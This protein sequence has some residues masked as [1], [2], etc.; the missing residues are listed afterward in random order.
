[1]PTC[2]TRY[3]A[4][5]QNGYTLLEVVVCLTLVALISGLVLRPGVQAQHNA[6]LNKA[7]SRLIAALEDQ[8]RSAISN[9]RI[10]TVNLSNG[11]LTTGAGNIYSAPETF[12]LAPKKAPK[13]EQLKPIEFYPDGSVNA[14]TLVLSKGDLALEI[15]VG[16]LSGRAYVK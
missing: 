5:S 13:S 11:R 7:A 3:Q 10:Q 6:K 12:T 2:Q 9:G 14:P 4:K 16:A 15:E 1:M 8:A